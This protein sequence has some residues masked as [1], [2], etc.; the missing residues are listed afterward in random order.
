MLFG[1]IACSI[2]VVMTW[3]S[4]GVLRPLPK[5]QRLTFNSLYSIDKAIKKYK[6]DHGT[7]PASLGHITNSSPFAVVVEDWWGND[8]EYIVL[9]E[10]NYSLISYGRDAKPGGVG[11][12]S[13]LSLQLTCMK[14]VRPTLFQFVTDWP[15]LS[16]IAFSWALISVIMGWMV[17]RR[18]ENKRCIA[19]SVFDAIIIVGVGIILSWGFLFIRLADNHF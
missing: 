10:A 6:D 2:A 4:I 5:Y 15:V 12:D 7:I 11:Y 13:D 19:T 9:D 3:G 1:L 17:R 18:Y 14:S 16:E 8:F